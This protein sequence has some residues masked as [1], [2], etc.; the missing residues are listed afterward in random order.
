MP[1]LY[2]YPEKDVIISR[3][4]FPYEIKAV[5]SFTGC[6]GLVLIRGS[7]KSLTLIEHT[8]DYFR[9]YKDDQKAFNLVKLGRTTPGWTSEILWQ[10]SQDWNFERVTGE[11]GNG[12]VQW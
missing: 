6:M 8:L 10:N 9:V 4:R 1:L 5:W 12:Y 7:N 2:L 11:T 3:G